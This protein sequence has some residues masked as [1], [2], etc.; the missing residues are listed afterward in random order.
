MKKKTSVK[1]VPVRDL[2]FKKFKK[3]VGIKVFILKYS[4]EEGKERDKEK[5]IYNKALLILKERNYLTYAI[6]QSNI[7]IFLT[8][9]GRKL[10]DEQD[11]WE[12]E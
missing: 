2:L 4:K 7:Q 1:S 6:H 9:V 12:K 10:V 3:A 8:D 5:I 11:Q